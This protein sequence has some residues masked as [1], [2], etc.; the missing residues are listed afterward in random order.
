MFRCIKEYNLDSEYPSR[1]IAVEIVELEKLK[2]IWR[3]LEKCLASITGQQEESR[4]KKRSS[5]TSAPTFQ[6]GQQQKSKFHRTTETTLSPYRSPSFTPVLLQ[7]GSSS[8]AYGQRGQFGNMAANSSEVD[9][10]SSLA[11]EIHGHRGQFGDIAANS[12]EVDRCSSLAYEIHG[13]RGQFGDMAANSIE[14]D[15]CFGAIDEVDPHFGAVENAGVH[16]ALNSYPFMPFPR[17]D[18]PY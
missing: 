2:E 18:G 7:S 11:Y 4:G 1:D 10:S 17:R 15:P 9:R 8:L 6:Q 12:I 3:G 5:I 16:N 13:H 14:V